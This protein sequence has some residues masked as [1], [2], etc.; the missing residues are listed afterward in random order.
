VLWAFVTVALDG[1][2]IVPREVDAILDIES[3]R[4]ILR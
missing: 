4:T 1:V 3:A 2:A